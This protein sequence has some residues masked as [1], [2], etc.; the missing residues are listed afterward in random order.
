MIEKQG[1][2]TI[3]ALTIQAPWKHLNIDRQ[4]KSKNFF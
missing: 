4:N 3:I 1:I 2:N